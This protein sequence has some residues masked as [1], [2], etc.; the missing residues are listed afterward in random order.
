MSRLVAPREGGSKR[1]EEEWKNEIQL[2][3]DLLVFIV[4][5]FDFESIF[6]SNAVRSHQQMRFK[7]ILVI[8]P[9]CNSIYSYRFSRSLNSVLRMMFRSDISRV[10]TLFSRLPIFP[11]SFWSHFP[12]TVT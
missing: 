10:D 11:P 2:R 4:A 7:R 1:R 6:T 5:E 3:I 8:L 12:G 9:S